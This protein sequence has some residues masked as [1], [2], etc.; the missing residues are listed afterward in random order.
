MLL[1]PTAT[2]TSP[3]FCPEYRAVYTAFTTKPSSS[4]AVQQNLMVKTLVDGGVW[5]KMDVFYNYASHTNGD[6]EALLDWKQPEGSDDLLESD[7]G[8]FDTDIEGWVTHINN[9]VTRVYDPDALND[10]ALKITYVD[11]VNGATWYMRDAVDL[12]AD[13]VIGKTYKLRMRCKSG[14]GT[15]NWYA[16]G[17]NH[18]VTGNITNAA[19]QW[20]EGLFTATHTTN[21]RLSCAGSMAP[22]EIT[23]IDSIEVMEWTNAT[24]YNAPT[25]TALEGFT[26]GATKYIDCN[27][28][29]SVNGVNFIKDSASI[30]VYSRT[31]NSEAATEIGCVDTAADDWMFAAL[32]WS[33][34][35][36]Y[37][38]NDN[39]GGSVLVANTTG[40]FIYTRTASNAIVAYRNKVSIDTDTDVST[41]IPSFN[42]FA[43]GR[44]VDGVLAAPSTKQLSMAFAGAGFTQT[45]VDN[46]TDR[47]EAYMDSNGKGVIT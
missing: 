28:N 38:L 10:Y 16:I 12:N 35:G 24:A 41:D 22:G 40:L 21:C 34:T 32:S 2:I 39:S 23:Y 1:L 45:D 18:F 5:T 29:P 20:Y 27:W 30:G 43:L 15:I 36:N 7:K 33:G 8:N 14:G 37:R 25:F 19:Y 42:M 6:G 44:N 9:N 11:G 13:L 4:V 46:L 26:G 31:D 17:P 47:F 3:K